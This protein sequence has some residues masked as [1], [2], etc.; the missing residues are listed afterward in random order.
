MKPRSTR[1]LTSILIYSISVIVALLV[2]F[3]VEEL[4]NQVSALSE[5]GSR[6]VFATTF[7]VLLVILL[8]V[9][10]Q[11]VKRQTDQFELLNK[12]CRVS[13]ASQT[14]KTLDTFRQQ[15]KRYL[16]AT[17]ALHDFG[18]YVFDWQQNMFICSEAPEQ[19]IIRHDHPLIRYAEQQHIPF[20][21][22]R[23][24]AQARGLSDAQL[25]ELMM[26][27]QRNKFLCMIPLYTEQG[28]YGFI[29][30]TLEQIKDTKLFAMKSF[31]SLK[32]FSEHFGHLLQKI[33]IYDAIVLKPNK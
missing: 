30:L 26:F 11:L 8:V 10:Q 32:Q 24:V 2:A 19:S 31:D 7:P 28:I 17:Y 1:Y 27:M 29:C 12:H 20:C 5:A 21:T 15:L 4:A 25:A 6:L 9:L 23:S 18:L 14:V 3:G 16:I 22:E 33:L 13:F